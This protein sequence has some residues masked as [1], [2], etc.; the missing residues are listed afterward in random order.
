MISRNT[1]FLHALVSSCN[2]F[3]CESFNP[4]F[5]AFYTFILAWYLHYLRNHCSYLVR[6]VR[7]TLMPTQASSDS[8]SAAI[9]AACSGMQLLFLVQAAE[10]WLIAGYG[11]SEI[12]CGCPSYCYCLPFKEMLYMLSLLWIYLEVHDCMLLEE[13]PFI[14]HALIHFHPDFEFLRQIYRYYPCPS[15]LAS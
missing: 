2:C 6:H 8:L 12:Q 14:A 7:L 4:K 10:F 5:N 1:K 11:L 9:R 13:L 15:L 3:I